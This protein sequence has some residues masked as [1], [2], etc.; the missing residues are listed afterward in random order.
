MKRLTLPAFNL[1]LPAAWRQRWDALGARE[2]LTILVGGSVLC[3]GLLLA[4][5]WLPLQRARTDLAMRLPEL[6]ARLA[7]LQQQGDEV[8]RIRS[9]PPL[10]TGAARALDTQVLRAAFAGAQVSALD[11]QHFRVIQDD[12]GYAAWIDALN[13]LQAQSA[14]RVET[15]TL[16]ALPAPGHVKIDVRFAAPGATP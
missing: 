9:L 10:T 7:T 16:T 11:G 14:A 6:R 13:R 3:V 5:A 4:Y 2:R 8:M 15:A 1:R 12:A